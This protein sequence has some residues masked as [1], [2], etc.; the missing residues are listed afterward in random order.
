LIGAA[1]VLILLY[2]RFKF[3]D[4][5]PIGRLNR[6]VRDADG[7]ERPSL[8]SRL[9][10]RLEKS[11]D[12]FVSVFVILVIVLVV[13]E[14]SAFGVTGV[15]HDSITALRAGFGTSGMALLTIIAVSLLYPIVDVVTWQRLAALSKDTGS[16]PDLRSAIIARIFNLLAPEVMLLLLL[17]C[18]FG[19]VA[20]VPTETPA[21]RDVLQT[22]I[23]LLTSEE[24][25]PASL[26]I[27]L[28]VLGILTMALSAA[29]S[30]L[31]ASLWVL[32]YDLLPVLWPM[33]SPERIRP[34]DE[35][36]ARRRTILVGCGLCAGA[37]LV[38]VAADTLFGMSFTPSTF[39][40]VL[41]ACFCAQ[42]SFISLVLA[43]LGLRGR[44]MG[45]VSGRWALLIVGGAVATGITVVIVFLATGAELW[46][47]AAV[48][49]CVG[50]GLMLFAIAWLCRG[51]PRIR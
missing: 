28:L 6:R 29:S 12:T 24:S 21:D 2:R 32:R 36:I 5:T 19:A 42:L 26:A 8:L 22:L 20:V 39:L 18:A 49:A 4:N 17:M 23:R 30:M 3:V 46:L 33:L 45:A 41:C 10:R 7:G 34:A 48:P 37:I 35:A 13:M 9:L 16:Q 11:I 15:A 50:S 47:W 25:L 38:V 1:C 31:S 27:S 14:F 44:C 40:A 51:Q 43:P